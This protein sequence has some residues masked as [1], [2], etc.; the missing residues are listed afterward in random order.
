RVRRRG[1][2]RAGRA[3]RRSR[4]APG[5]G[6]AG[7]AA[8]RARDRH[9]AERTLRRHAGADVHGV[10]RRRRRFRRRRGRPRRRG[11]PVRAHAAGAGAPAAARPAAAALRLCGLPADQQPLASRTAP[12]ARRRAALA[13]TRR[14]APADP[15]PAAVAAPRP[16]RPPARRGAMSDAGVSTAGR[17]TRQVGGDFVAMASGV[18]LRGALATLVS[19]VIA[20]A[21]APADMGRYAF[22]IWLAALLPVVLSLGVPTTITRYTA[23]AVGGGR[24]R[25]AGALLVRLPGRPGGAQRGRARRAGVVGLARGP[26]GRHRAA[27]AGRAGRTRRGRRALRPERQPDRCPRCDRLAAHRGRVPPGV[28]GAGRDRV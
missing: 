19:I 6:G 5:R 23:E 3:R 10:P 24:P 1:G 2:R 4:R 15:R 28:L 8:G 26:G 9:D 25:A 13:A 11:P 22:L 16:R 17:R 20:R 18:L 14:R 12:P 7:G 21:L 27:G